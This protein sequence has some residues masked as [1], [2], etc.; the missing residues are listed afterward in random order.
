VQSSGWRQIPDVAFD[1][2]H[3]N[4]PAAV[5]DSKDYGASTPWITQGGTSLSAPCWAGLIA[6]V[7]QARASAGLASLDGVTQTLPMIYDLPAS[8]FHDITEGGYTKLPAGPGYDLISGRGSP[9]ANLLVPAMVTA[10]PVDMILN[11]TFG[12]WTSGATMLPWTATQGPFNPYCDYYSPTDYPG[13]TIGYYNDAT[14][15]S[16]VALVNGYDYVNQWYSTFNGQ[17]AGGSQQNF[18]AVAGAVAGLPDLYTGV[19]GTTYTLQGDLRAWTGGGADLL[20]V[21]TEAMDAAEAARLEA[22][23]RQGATVLLLPGAPAAQALGLQTKE[24]RLFAGHAAAPLA[25]LTDGDLFLKRWTT[26]RAG[27]AGSGWNVTV[28]PGLVCERKVGAGRLV[29]HPAQV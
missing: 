13:K 9:I 15:I 19:T 3:I 12:T 5:Y 10:A 8:V 26:L 18:Q 7:N 22:A 23:A 21:G 27:V 17:P 25:G 24:E 1:A 28:A 4:S 11:G 6:I 16:N 2:D 29:V 14:L 20:V